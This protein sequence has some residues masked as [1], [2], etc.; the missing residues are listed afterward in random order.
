MPAQDTLRQLR[1]RAER[2]L[3][4]VTRPDAQR[5]GLSDDQVTR[6]VANGHLDRLHQG[7]YALAGTPPTTEHQALAACLA[8]G[9]AWAS[10]RTACAIWGA[11]EHPPDEPEVTVGTD[12]RPRRPGVTIY[13]TTRL[14]K[15][16]FTKRGVVPITSPARTLVD[17]AALLSYPDLRAVADKAFRHELITPARLVAYIDRQPALPGIHRLRALADDRARKGIPGS[18]LEALAI[19]LIETSGLPDPIRQLPVGRFFIDVA[20]PEQMVAIELEGKDHL[21]SWQYDHDRHNTL[22]LAGWRVLYFTWDD[23]TEHPTK[24]VVAIAEAVGLRAVRWVSAR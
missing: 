22:E 17:V 19:E 23:V 15:R 5:C 10:H 2:Q 16:D 18:E 11:A 24:V 8:C 13:R 4:I 12:R 6:L 9:S 3:Q 20:Y 14:A 21:E 7:V 1:R